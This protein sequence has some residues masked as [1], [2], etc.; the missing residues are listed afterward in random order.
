MDMY[1]YEDLGLFED[2]ARRYETC[3]RCRR[4]IYP[5]EKADVG[6]ALH[7]NCFRCVECNVTLTLSGA[8]IA[9]PEQ[10]SRPAVYCQSHAPKPIKFALDEQSMEIQ[11]AVKVQRTGDNL[12]FNKQ[13]TIVFSLLVRVRVCLY[14]C[15]Y[16]TFSVCVVGS[17][18]GNNR[19]ALRSEKVCSKVRWMFRCDW[20][21]KRTTCQLKIG[22]YIGSIIP[23]IFSSWIHTEIILWNT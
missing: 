14:S 12:I 19:K 21:Y 10:G 6:V 5:T 22:N 8:I 18:V 9:T 23:T 4:D 15:T 13:V 2:S 20:F 17:M 11:N 16:G 1:G 7:K 3:I